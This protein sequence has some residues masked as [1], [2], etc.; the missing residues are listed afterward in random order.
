MK[1]N[2]PLFVKNSVDVAVV[3]AKVDLKV[4]EAKVVVREKVAVVHRVVRVKAK[5]VLN[6]PAVLNEVFE[7]DHCFKATKT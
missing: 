2:V 5:V 3:M 4:D 6:A 1:K 7:A